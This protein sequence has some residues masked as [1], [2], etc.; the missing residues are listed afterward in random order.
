MRL[1][2]LGLLLLLASLNEGARAN[3]IEG[4]DLKNCC[5]VCMDLTSIQCRS[6][7]SKAWAQ[8]VPPVVK[9]GKLDAVKANE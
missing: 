1:T 9:S 8:F 7:Q 4:Q 2:V 5:P 3:V 6:D